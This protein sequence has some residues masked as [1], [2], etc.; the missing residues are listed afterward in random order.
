LSFRAGGGLE[1]EDAKGIQFEEVNDLLSGDVLTGETVGPRDPA[2]EGIE[3]EEDLL[4]PEKLNDE[5]EEG[6]EIEGE[7]TVRRVIRW[8]CTFV[9]SALFLF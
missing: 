7:G 9:K 5:G 2:M 4:A 1:L 6:L 8:R 3:D